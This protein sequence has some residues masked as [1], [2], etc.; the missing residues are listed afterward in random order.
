MPRLTSLVKPL[1]EMTTEE[2]REHLHRIR[3]DRKLRKE[4]PKA[5]KQTA[6]KRAT[7]K[8]KVTALL[9]GLSEEQ[10]AALHAQMEQENG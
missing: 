1:D 5:K 6:R 10:R 2:L 3:E 8:E 4:A 7:A 9:E